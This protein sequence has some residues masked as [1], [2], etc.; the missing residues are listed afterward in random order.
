LLA[1]AG[2]LSSTTRELVENLYQWERPWLVDDGAY[3][4]TFGRRATAVSETVEQAVD[5]YAT[6]EG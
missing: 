6:H 2:V 5:W 1:L 3:R 4:N